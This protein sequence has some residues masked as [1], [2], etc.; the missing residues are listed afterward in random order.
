MSVQVISG[1]NDGNFPL[2]GKTIAEARGQLGAALNISGDAV[3]TLNDERAT[4]TDVL[5]DG[6]VLTFA[7]ATAEKGA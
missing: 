6:D 4:A 1:A 7:R 2:A 3:A 5:A